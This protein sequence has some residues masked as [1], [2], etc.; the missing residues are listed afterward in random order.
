LPAGQFCQLFDGLGFFLILTNPN[1]ISVL[2]QA[3]TNAIA[4]WANA[5][6]AAML[7]DAFRIAGL[8]SL[9]TD[10]A[11][12]AA[13][14]Y[15]YAD[16]LSDPMLD[17]G[18]DL[19]DGF[20]RGRDLKRTAA[21]FLYNVTGDQSY[22]N[23]VYNISVCS[24]NPATLKIGGSDSGRNQ[25][26]AAAAYL[27]TNQ[28][29][30]YPAFQ[31]N[32]KTQIINEALDV[33][34]GK[35]ESRPSRRSTDQTPSFWR[36]AHFVQRT[37]IARAVADNPADKDVLRKALVLEADWG[38]GRNPLNMIQMTTA[39]TPLESKRS[40][41]EAY[42]AGMD[43]GIAGVHPGHTPYMNLNDW[44]SMVMSRPSAL[45][46]NSY[47]ADVRSTWPVGEAYFPSR[48]V[49]AHNEF[50]PRQTM[51]G[52]MA[53]FGYLYGLAENHAPVNTI[54]TVNNDAVDDGGGTVTSQPGDIDC[55]IDCDEAYQHGAS[56]T[57]TADPDNGSVFSG[58]SGA[59]SGNQPECNV[60]MTMNRSV[61][62][63][64]EPEDS[65]TANQDSDEGD[66]NG[67]GAGGGCF[68]SALGV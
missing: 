52:K 22:E 44:G 57:L 32:L 63:T 2:Y 58:W 24:A 28:T 47:P 15:Q 33:E 65:G 68:I 41:T 64:F 35:C 3:G 43:D 60:I 67:S 14:A 46:N 45:Y 19:D 1:G 40:V 38:L 9:M 61:T 10:Y 27:K 29:V 11:D 20:L 13:A 54:L 18:L 59:C 21:A 7:A 50:T 53:L 49:W 36:T 31:Q 42:T 56:V 6:N 8:T 66:G 25:M 37:I 30:H 17:E 16:D 12:K 62:A 48:W 34:A 51:R 55:G 5:V 39:F 23:V 4:A 26:Y